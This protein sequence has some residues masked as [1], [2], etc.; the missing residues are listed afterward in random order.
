MYNEVTQTLNKLSLKDLARYEA[1]FQDIRPTTQREIFRRGVFAL[2]SVHT[3]WEFNVA[4]YAQL[5]DLKWLKDVEKLRA[6]IE[7]S[8]AGLVNI[9]V[10]AYTEYAAL[11]WQFPG[12]LERRKD[13]TWY[14]FRDRI[15]DTVHGL[16]PA[17][18]AFYA[19]LLYFQDSRVPCMDTHMLQLYGVP[20]KKVNNV[21][22]GDRIRMETHFDVTCA[23]LDIRPVTAR[24][25]I[26]DKKQGKKNPRYWSH[27]LE[28]KPK[29]SRPVQISFAL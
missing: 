26:W 13:E 4:L 2:A 29:T 9:R 21:K 12:L 16:G 22:S 25:L 10:R 23:N 17:K 6:K 14:A 24:W 15:M 27:V 18:A 28:G 1:Y 19:E 11:F 8:R 3:T 20:T 7:E 5:W